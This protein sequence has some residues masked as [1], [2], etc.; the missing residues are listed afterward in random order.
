M[1]NCIGKKY[2]KL[3]VMEIFPKN[4]ATAK[5]RCDC[6]TVKTIHWYKVWS[7]AT[8]S[9]GCRR[10]EVN[11]KG[12]STRTVE[13]KTWCSIKKRCRV[14]T[15]THERYKKYYTG[16]TVCDRWNG[17]DGYKN[18]LAD[19]GNRPDGHTIDRIDTSKGY[20]PDNCRWA[21][22]TEQANN[23]TNN[24]CILID[25]ERTTAAELARLA[26]VSYSSAWSY[27]DR[28]YRPHPVDTRLISFLETHSVTL[29]S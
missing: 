29:P 26:G 2:N 12:Y 19:M 10:K 22:M 15:K 11:Y 24:L 5:C 1:L 21:T 13:Y 7:G 25:G 23:K 9:C 6:G 18:F 20:S 28:L 8:V 4:R 3:T 17:K 14:G 27:V 16:I